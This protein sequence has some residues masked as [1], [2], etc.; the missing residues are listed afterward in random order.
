MRLVAASIMMLTG[1]VGV[2]ARTSSEIDPT[3]GSVIVPGVLFWVGLG[4]CVFEYSREG[5]S[6]G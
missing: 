4:L 5:K 2:T 3:I 1:M 6:G